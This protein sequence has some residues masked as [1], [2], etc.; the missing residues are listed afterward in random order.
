MAHTQMPDVLGELRR[1]IFRI[2]K[3]Q[4][5]ALGVRIRQYRPGGNLFT[6]RKAHA[7]SALV[8]HDNLVNCRISANLHAFGFGKC[9]HCLGDG[10]HAA[11]G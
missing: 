6:A 7:A 2:D 10:A 4:K 11:L 9:R 8:L 5:G 3:F 1:K